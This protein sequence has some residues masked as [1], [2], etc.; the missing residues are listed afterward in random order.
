MEYEI[1][2]RTK[3]VTVAHIASNQHICDL[4]NLAELSAVKFIR[5][6]KTYT[7]SGKVVVELGVLKR[8]IVGYILIE[9]DFLWT[10]RL[11]DWRHIVVI[12]PRFD[13]GAYVFDGCTSND[14]QNIVLKK[15]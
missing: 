9:T 14:A 7:F 15:Y 5:D 11:S 12:R 4:F 1:I 8:N 6:D 3:K 13:N 10:T 2:K